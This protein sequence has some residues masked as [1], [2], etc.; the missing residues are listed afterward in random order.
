MTVEVGE[1]GE[2]HGH[3]FAHV[4]AE[5]ANRDGARSDEQ[6]VEPHAVEVADGLRAGHREGGEQDAGRLEAFQVQAA[7]A[8]AAAA[9]GG[10]VVLQKP[11]QELA[12]NGVAERV[13]EALGGGWGVQWC[14]L[15]VV[16]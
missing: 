15:R 1:E 13:V 16:L 9:R 12:A 7:P 8:A 10:D 14:V 6:P 2:V 4:A 3:A 5:G 11:H